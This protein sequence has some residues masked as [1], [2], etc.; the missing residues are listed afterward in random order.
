[1]IGRLMQTPGCGLRR[2]W[3]VAA[4]L[5]VL[6]E[7]SV[8]QAPAADPARP[9]A[10][11]LEP[12]AVSQ[13]E[14]S[15][16]DVPAQTVPRTLQAPKDVPQALQPLVV[17]QL[18]ERQRDAELE[19]GRTFSLSF[20]EAIPIKDLLLLL[21][22]DTTL[23]IVPDPDIDGTFIGELKNVTV[24]QALELILRP[25]ALDY[26]VQGSF[27]RVFKNRLDT[28]LFDVNY[29]VT[30]RSSQRTLSASSAVGGGGSAAAVSSE[31]SGDL[32]SELS[33]GIQTLLS[34]DGKFNLDRKA[35]LLQV[36]DHADRLDKIGVYLEIVQMR[37]WRQV[38][39]QANVVEVELDDQHASGIDWSAVLGSA[40]Q[41]VK[42]TQTLAPATS[43]GFTLGMNIRD[44]KGLL[45]AFAAQGKVNVLSSPR[46]L[47]MNNEPAIMRIGTQDVFFVTTSQ[48]DATTGK[49]VQTTVTPQPITEGIV[50]SVTPQI[51]SDGTVHMSIN[52]SVTE[53]T[54]QATSRLGD[55]VPIIS[56]RETDTVVRVHQNET[57]VISGLMLER[58][59]PGAP[60]F[61]GLFGHEETTR[62]K[63]DLVILL[64]PTIVTPGAILETAARDGRQVDEAQKTPGQK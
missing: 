62:R 44:F 42:V 52:P 12:M 28:R 5:I 45:D 31:E 61:G 9:E 36:T 6:S 43:G 54:G 2:A 60:R 58:V 38:Q 8:A 13:L 30:R 41:S 23:S 57:I 37:A 32:F 25:L 46:V 49:V 17:T 40:G 19:G 53:R 33:G 47:A 63:T 51:A 39:I 15:R 16:P 34:P 3:Q 21:V 27:I 4:L 22:R 14:P 55:T 56:V 59:T 18:D 10:R 48:V 20:S 26:S 50:L 64:T 11:P 24:R 7:P 1:M 35:G 29:V